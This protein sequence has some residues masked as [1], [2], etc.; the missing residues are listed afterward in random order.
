MPIDRKQ[1]RPT[2]S[3][4][5][6]AVGKKYVTE[7]NVTVNKTGPS[8]TKKTQNRQGTVTERDLIVSKK[9]PDRTVVTAG[10]GTG[11]TKEKRLHRK[12]ERPNCN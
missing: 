9:G 3:K 5:D 8:V 10:L 11:E 6:Q 12:D 2:I 1:Q 4:E 7:E